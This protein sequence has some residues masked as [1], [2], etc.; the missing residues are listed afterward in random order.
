MSW[1]VCLTFALINLI[2][3][4]LCVYDRSNN[5]IDL[6]RITSFSCICLGLMG[7]S[8]TF[9]IIIDVYVIFLFII[10]IFLFIK[11]SSFCIMMVLLYVVLCLLLLDIVRAFS[12]FI[13]L[14]SLIRC[15][16][17]IY[18]IMFAQDF[19]IVGIFICKLGTFCLF[20]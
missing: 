12:S 13:P 20:Y 11:S 5:C 16:N 6:R 18:R 7:F 9:V 15:H 4:I 17:R 3:F 10:V 8:I 1:V 19:F 2:L 14:G